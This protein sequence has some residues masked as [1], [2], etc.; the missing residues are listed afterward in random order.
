[1]DVSKV[2]PAGATLTYQWYRDDERILGAIKET[3]TPTAED[4]GK[5]VHVAVSAEKCT[6]VLKSEEVTVAKADALKNVKYDVQVWYANPAVQTVTVDV[7]KLPKSVEG[8]EIKT[9]TVPAVNS[10]IIST[11]DFTGTTFKLADGLTPA[12]AGKT[13]SWTV[14]ITS[15]THED[16]TGTVTVTVTADAPVVPKPEPK[17]EPSQPGRLYGR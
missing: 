3:Y 13:A 14:T 11:A 10:G 1:M 6:G 17:P 15:K 4:I 2:E 5:S 8:A 7:F 9:D 12:D 16:T